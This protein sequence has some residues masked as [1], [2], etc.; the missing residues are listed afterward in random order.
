MPTRHSDAVAA[1]VREPDRG[2]GFTATGSWNAPPDGSAPPKPTA[3]APAGTLPR[4]IVS[5][6]PGGAVVSGPIITPSI[7][8]PAAATGCRSVTAV[9][10]IGCSGVLFFGTVT[11][12][13][14]P[15]AV[16]RLA[17]PPGKP[18]VCDVVFALSSTGVATA[19]AV[20]LAT[21]TGPAGTQPLFDGL[22]GLQAS[23]V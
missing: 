18:T 16:V 6:V 9:I 13:C 20:S 11:V 7:S 5:V 23:S 15:S 3:R 17:L 22:A 21:F 1:E 19:G 8:L 10:V 12:Y 14:V 2:R 4:L